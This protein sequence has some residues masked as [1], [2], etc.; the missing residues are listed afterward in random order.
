[1]FWYNVGIRTSVLVSK[2]RF[3]EM[4]QRHRDYR[5]EIL[6]FLRGH[7]ADHG[8]APTLEEIRESMGLS[9]KSHVRYYLGAL[10][11]DG[12]IER[13]PRSPRGL[14]VVGTATPGGPG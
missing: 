2:G 1:M 4:S 10:E 13:K 9:S 8:Y 11:N 5:Q 14:S 7:I 6:A 3:W 12:L